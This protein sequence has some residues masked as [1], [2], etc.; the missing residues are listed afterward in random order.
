MQLKTRFSCINV[1]ESQQDT[2]CKCGSHHMQIQVLLASQPKPQRVKTTKDVPCH[3][4]NGMLMHRADFVA[5]RSV[6]DQ[7]ASSDQLMA[8]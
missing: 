6:P 5:D 7:I 8:S 4:T 2:R 1:L 3:G